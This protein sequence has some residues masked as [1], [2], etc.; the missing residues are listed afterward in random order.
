MVKGKAENLTIKSF[1]KALKGLRDFH[2][3]TRQKDLKNLKCHP[4]HPHS[5]QGTEKNVLKTWCG[6][7]G[8]VVTSGQIHR[9]TRS[10][11]V[12][13]GSKRKRNEKIFYRQKA[14]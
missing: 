2:S 6:M 14:S 8:L 13:L 12:N 5:V 7:L 11:I 10:L 1:N 3:S 4:Q 9:E